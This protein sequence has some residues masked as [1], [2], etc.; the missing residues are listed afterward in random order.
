[1]KNRSILFLNLSSLEY[2]NI[3]SKLIIHGVIFLY[4]KY[5]H[6][7]LI[8][9]IVMILMIVLIFS[10]NNLIKNVMNIIK[11]RPLDNK[12]IVIDPG[13]GGIDGGTNTGDVLEKN[14]NLAIALKLRDLLSK[15]GANVVMTRETD[16]SLD[17]GIIGNG[18]RHREDL[19]KRVDIT[20]ENDADLFISIHVNHIKNPKRIG[21][22]V[23]YHEDDMDSRDLAFHIQEYLNK[24]ESYKKVDTS[25]NHSA[26]S[27]R[28]FILG[29]IQMP[30][31]IVET[32]FISN[33]IERELLLDEE[34]QE[35]IVEKLTEGII[36][37]FNKL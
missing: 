15:K 13:H 16:I 9:F 36:T 34:H 18:S 22:I 5:K 28:Y 29:N 23:F 12:I 14:I 20:K 32:G 10:R 17:D 8:I 3:V 2:I 26:T 25:I 31:I 11:V 4:I 21:P 37:Y 19:N 1:M 33:K 7:Y 35:K 27:G 30:G 6:L 24:V